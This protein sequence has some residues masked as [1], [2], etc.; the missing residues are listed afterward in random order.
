[1]GRHHG[2]RRAGGSLF[3]LLA[4]WLTASVVLGQQSAVQEGADSQK[5]AEKRP[6]SPLSTAY[7]PDDVLAMNMARPRRLLQ[8]PAMAPVRE[9]IAR[10]PGY[11]N[12]L[13]VPIEEIDQVTSFGAALAVPDRLGNRVAAR[14]M[15]LDVSTAAAVATALKGLKGTPVPALQRERTPI[16][17]RPKAAGY[18]AVVNKTL[19][20]SSASLDALRHAI[21]A[22]PKGKTPRL[23]SDWATLSRNDAIWLG[24]DVM[25]PPPE[26]RGI[27]LAVSSLANEVKA[28][29]LALRVEDRL[30]ASFTLQAKGEESARRANEVFPGFL[31]VLRQGLSAVPDR[32]ALR[33]DITGF[34]LSEFRQPIAAMLAEARSEVRGSTLVARTHHEVDPLVQKMATLIPT[35]DTVQ[36]EELATRDLRNLQRI[37]KAIDTYKQEHGSFPPAYVPGPDGKT[38][39]SWRVALLPYL[40]EE[41][42]YADYRRNEPWDS[43]ANRKLL[44][45]IPSVYKSPLD[46]PASVN[47]SYFVFVGPHAPFEGT[48]P[49]PVTSVYDGTSNTFLAVEA[50]RDIPWTKPEDIEFDENRPL[51]AFGGRRPE[52]FLAAFCDG[53]ADLVP[54][55]VPKENLRRFIVRDN[56]GR[57]P[58]L[59]KHESDWRWEFQERKKSSR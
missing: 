2:W 18:Y 22:G 20:L 35:A 40:D 24:T 15:V 58:R 26:V 56:D 45:R 43:P 7:L 41:G 13:G 34:I 5:P 46:P 53:T 8:L 37:A 49:V 19:I 10:N 29:E 6:P 28:I 36:A 16:F 12:I 27:P 21:D 52:G 1:M 47:S 55:E 59:E 51:P 48:Q 39:H 23:A 57:F 30:K 4:M 33:T 31:Q 54:L 25:F 11:V 42:L 14:V 9:A 38:L 50:Q 44:K 17:E 3:I 32:G